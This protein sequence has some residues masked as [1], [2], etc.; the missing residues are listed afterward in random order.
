[1]ILTEEDVALNLKGELT[2][3]QVSKIRR[4][5]IVQL[6]A[7]LC[8]LVLVP[9]SV[10]MANIHWGILLIIWL[11]AGLFFAGIFLWSAWTYLLMKKSGLDIHHISG[12][13]ELKTS[14]NKNVVVKIGE[15]SFFMTRNDSSSIING[16]DYTLYFLENPKLPIGWT[17]NVAKESAAE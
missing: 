4:K 8:F 7:G 9:A 1:M 10:L 17:Q 14:G 3:A 2:A 16:A 6:V 13:V 15:R 11:V 12:K 5:G